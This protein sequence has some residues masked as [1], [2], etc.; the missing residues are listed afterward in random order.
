MEYLSRAI[1]CCKSCSAQGE[2]LEQLEAKLEVAQIQKM[3]LE[4]VN[5]KL[6]S[7][8]G[9]GGED[10][11]QKIDTKTLQDLA[12]RL[13]SQLFSITTVSFQYLL[14]VLNR[15]SCM[16]FVFSCMPTMPHL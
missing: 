1:I 6:Q 15:C 3:I 5:N 7:Q 2:L 14:S 9:G 10:G 16:L 4:W 8:M 11:G 13:N 12:N